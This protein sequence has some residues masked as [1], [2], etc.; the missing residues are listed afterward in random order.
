MNP[1]YPTKS[2]LIWALGVFVTTLAVYAMTM[3]ATITLEDAGLFQMVCHNG[4]IG[5]PPGYPLFI[6]A[7]QGFVDLPVFAEGVFAGNLLSAVF[8][9]LSCVCLLFVCFEIL[10]DKH[11]SVLVTLFYGFSATFWSQ[12]IIIE[13]YTLSVFLFL[14]CLWLCL[15][16]VRTQDVRSLIALAFVYGL[17]LANHWPLQGLATMSLVAVLWPVLRALWNHV[18]SVRFFPVFAISL[19][20]GLSPY[21]SLFQDS[22]TIAIYGSIETWDEFLNYVSRT[23][24]E[25]KSLAADWRDHRGFQSWLIWQTF[26]EYSFYLAP[27]LLGGL[28]LSFRQF[29]LSLAI[30]LVLLYLGA[31]SLLVFLLGFEF[32]ALRI[33]IFKP[34]PIIAY[35]APA[36]WLGL[37]CRW[38]LGFIHNQAPRVEKV[39]PVLLVLIV[40]VSNFTGNN[41]SSN[42]FAQRYGKQ[43]LALIPENAVL[44]VEGDNGVGLVGYLL[45]VANLRQDLELRSW[46]NLVFE[47]RL[48][49]AFA[50]DKTQD[51]ARALF[52]RNSERPVW[53]TVNT[54]SPLINRG[55]VFGYQVFGDNADAK[56]QCEAG[57]H[58]YVA[59]LLELEQDQYLVDGHERELLFGLLLDFT[60]LHVGL[61][62]FNPDSSQEEILMLQKLQQTF[63]GK[64]A[65]L[66]TM[67]QYP[68]DGDG[69]EKLDELAVAASLSL[70]SGS[71]RQV[72]SVLQEFHGKI[73]MMS[74]Q[75][76]DGAITHFEDSIAHYPVSENTSLCPLYQAYLIKG[77]PTK[78]EKLRTRFEGLVCD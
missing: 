67:I 25:D 71:S 48:S 37:G 41:R 52:F 5:H 60:R 19:L 6:L 68:Q 63:A 58:D 43:V 24:Y 54:G 9:S 51:Q 40:L 10:G 53:S 18:F 30:G 78:A 62:L 27:L 32:N 12:A 36:I 55:I 26:K 35:V 42:E 13:V 23:A 39:L 31:T 72:A 66:E 11:L 38:L 76:I 33:A 77:S 4:G 1:V 65:T 28:V 14:A 20:L 50:T 47:N 70:P 3:P 46:R 64:I 16:Y 57:V 7:C 61:L 75:N 21:L 8:A 69:K 29:R 34:Y 22:P 59:Y 17:A 44:F 2:L 49:S 15:I 45:K 74:P 73:A 56:Y